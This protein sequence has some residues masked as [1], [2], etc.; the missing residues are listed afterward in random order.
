LFKHRPLMGGVLLITASYY[1]INYIIGYFILL[2]L[3]VDVIAVITIPIIILIGNVPITISG[4]GLR[5]SVGAVC[6]TLLGGEGTYG[7]SFSLILFGIITLIPGL[8]GY[9][10]AM[11]TGISST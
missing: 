3:N 2:A 8:A 5:E 6:F 7:F 11:K 9:I 4:L 1:A 10:L